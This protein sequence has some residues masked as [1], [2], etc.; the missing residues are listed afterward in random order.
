MAEVVTT[1]AMPPASFWSI[2]C[3]VVPSIPQMHSITSGDVQSSRGAE[4]S[5]CSDPS[6]FRV[7][8]QVQIHLPD[9]QSAFSIA[10]KQPIWKLHQNTRASYSSSVC[11]FVL[12]PICNFSS[13]LK[14][15]QYDLRKLMDLDRLPARAVSIIYGMGNVWKQE[16]GS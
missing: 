15:I 12:L 14:A 1:S 8:I 5:L 16:L 10:W 13:L 3:S 6:T 9:R 11:Y 7:R 2:S 4:K